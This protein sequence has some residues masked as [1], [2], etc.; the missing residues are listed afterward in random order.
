MQLAVSAFIQN[1]TAPL[2]AVQMLTPGFHRVL[3]VGTDR[4]KDGIPEQVNLLIRRCIREYLGCPGNRRIGYDAPA[5]LVGHQ[6]LA[7]RSHCCAGGALI[8]SN[9]AGL[10]PVQQI[11]IG[12][13]HV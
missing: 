13:H 7:V 3:L 8:V 2:Q 1:I 11:R 9:P 12:R 6:H 10:N 5:D 4:L